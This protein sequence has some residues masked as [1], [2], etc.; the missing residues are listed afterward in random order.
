MRALS[1]GIRC[2]VRSRSD[3]DCRGAFLA[4]GGCVSEFEID[5]G[6]VIGQ[7]D[8]WTLVVNR[9]Q[10]L[11]GRAIVALNRTCRDVRDLTTAEWNSL[12]DE[13]GRVTYALDTLFD[14]DH[15]NFAFLMNVDPH[16]HLHVIPRYAEPRTW[17][18]LTFRDIDYGAAMKTSPRILHHDDLI[19][20]AEAVRE[21]LP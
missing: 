8:L 12:R 16:V 17:R 7:G 13:V 4:Y 19:A 9:N 14:P 6:T 11:L 18:R 15:Y 5:P 3:S 21:S 10:N 2:S 1:A 20:L